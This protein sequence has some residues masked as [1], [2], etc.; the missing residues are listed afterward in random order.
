MLPRI[1]RLTK[2]KAFERVFE[3]GAISVGK[4]ILF[5]F[6]QSKDNDLKFGFIVSSKVSNKAVI[7]NK[8]KRR[9]RAIIWPNIKNIKNN[10]NCIII[11][12]ARIKDASFLEIKKELEWHLIKIRK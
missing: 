7:R 1:N 6:S 12:L 9:L 3:T 8:I 5:K 4:F 10:Y 2:K 11:A